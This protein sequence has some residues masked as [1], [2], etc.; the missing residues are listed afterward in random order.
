MAAPASGGHPRPEVPG[1]RLGP[2]RSRGGSGHARDARR[3]LGELARRAGDVPVVLVGHSMGGRAALRA[4]D[5]PQVRAVPA[6]APWC[7]DASR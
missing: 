4:A 1:S 7:P 5:A 6:L 3:A 2:I